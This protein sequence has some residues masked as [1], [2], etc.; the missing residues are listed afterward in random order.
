MSYS[1]LLPSTSP[2]VNDD[3]GQA[4]KTALEELIV[5]IGVVFLYAYT[6]IPGR[7]HTFSVSLE[8]FMSLVRR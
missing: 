2:K 3:N 6:C 4:V 7:P 1:S 5:E 8:M